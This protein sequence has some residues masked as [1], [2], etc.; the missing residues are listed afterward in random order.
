[1]YKR[2]IEQDQRQE[3]STSSERT[4]EHMIIQGTDYQA[5]GYRPEAKII[6]KKRKP[7]SFTGT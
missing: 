7:S 1:M 3:S 6:K 2:E 5:F 4:N